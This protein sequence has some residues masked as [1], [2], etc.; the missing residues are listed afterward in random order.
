VS[1]V[2]FPLALRCAGNPTLGHVGFKI[3]ATAAL[4]LTPKTFVGTGYVSFHP[5]NG[6]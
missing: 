5:K 6:S 2:E 3:W 1:T 4:E